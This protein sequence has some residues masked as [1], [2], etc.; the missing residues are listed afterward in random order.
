MNRH[1]P[2]MDPGG[3]ELQSVWIE[4]AVLEKVFF[5]IFKGSVELLWLDNSV[6]QK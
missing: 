3:G 5:S 6:P 1:D 2:D 4:R